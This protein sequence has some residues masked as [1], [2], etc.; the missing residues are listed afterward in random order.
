MNPTIEFRFSQSVAPQVIGKGLPYSIMTESPC[1]CLPDTGE[2]CHR[3]NLS[4]S[5]GECLTCKLVGNSEQSIYSVKKDKQKPING[6]TVDIVRSRTNSWK[7]KHNTEP[8]LE[9][10]YRPIEPRKYI[11]GTCNMEGCEDDA[12]RNL[13]TYNLIFC[14]SHMS[15]AAGRVRSLKKRKE[16]ITIEKITKKPE[17]IIFGAQYTKN[18]EEAKKHK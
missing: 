13:A 18:R 17:K 15:T 12:R 1:K 7:R 10:L 16:I 9:Y 6:I 11:Q 2:P 8:P 4:K 5:E 3:I 14:R